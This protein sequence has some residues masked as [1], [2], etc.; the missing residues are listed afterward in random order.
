SAERPLVAR[1]PRLSPCSWLP[2]LVVQGGL[3]C[4]GTKSRS[5]R[6]V[7]FIGSG[8][9][10]PVLLLPF[11]WAVAFR[12]GRHID[13]VIHAGVPRR[14]NL[15]RLRQGTVD[16]PTPRAIAFLIINVAEAVI[17]HALALPPGKH[18]RAE[19]IACPPGKELGKN[20]HGLFRRFL[21][22]APGLWPQGRA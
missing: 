15:R 19:G 11:V 13:G 9:I 12:R 1:H 14:R 8:E 22:F 6:P 20:S 16:H 7:G 17:A 2:R 10:R 5:R 3:A 4:V 21:S 18:A